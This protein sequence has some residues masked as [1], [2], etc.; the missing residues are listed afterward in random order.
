LA[1]TLAM[2]DDRQM[3]HDDW[4][5]YWL[6]RAHNRYLDALSSALA[7]T[8]LDATMWRI[9][10][11]LKDCEWLSVSEIA[12]QANTK[13]STMTKAVQRMEAAGL[14]TSRPGERDRRV[15]EVRMTDAGQAQVESAVAAT[16]HVY[17]RAFGNIDQARLKALTELL[18]EVAENLR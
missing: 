16:R 6:T 5:F 17:N 15:T 13:L 2:T 4:P 12:V 11:I 8:G 10:M 1:S 3:S 7:G 18:G 14:V 9:T